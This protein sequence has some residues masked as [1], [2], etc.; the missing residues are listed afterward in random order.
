MAAF[1]EPDVDPLMAIAIAGVPRAVCVKNKG[2]EGVSQHKLLCG[3]Y[4]IVWTRARTKP[5]W[6][7]REGTRA[8]IRYHDDVCDDDDC[9]DLSEDTGYFTLQDSHGLE[10][11]GPPLDFQTCPT[12]IGKSMFRCLLCVPL[13]TS[14]SV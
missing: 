12:P 14:I 3:E 8:I 9:L 1:V 13:H 7:K 11:V 10:F 6:K 4:D 2:E 5:F